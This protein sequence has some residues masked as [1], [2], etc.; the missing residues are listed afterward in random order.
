M[1][2]NGWLAVIAI[3]VVV[4]ALLLAFNHGAHKDDADDDSH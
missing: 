4:I 3:W 2:T 1:T